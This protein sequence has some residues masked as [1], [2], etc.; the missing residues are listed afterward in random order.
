LTFKEF[1]NQQALNS[2]LVYLALKIRSFDLIVKLTALKA[3]KKLAEEL[4]EK[5]QYA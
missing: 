2:A 3:L 4:E 5:A 1:S